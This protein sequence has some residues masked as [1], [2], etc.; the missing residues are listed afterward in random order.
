M[1]RDEP[2]TLQWKKKAA[3]GDQWQVQAPTPETYFDNYMRVMKDRIL[4]P[5]AAGG[6]NSFP[7][8]TIA[9][10][11]GS[12]L[13]KV[14]K[15]ELLYACVHN[16]PESYLFDF[17]EQQLAAAMEV[18]KENRP[19]RR[20]EIRQYL[21]EE[22]YNRWYDPKTGKELKWD[23]I[24]FCYEG[25]NIP[26]T[27]AEVDREERYGTGKCA[28]EKKRLYEY[29]DGEPLA[30]AY[31]V[32]CAPTRKDAKYDIF[33]QEKKRQEKRK[34]DIRTAEEKRKQDVKKAVLEQEQLRFERMLIKKKEQQ[35]RRDAKKTE[36]H[37]N[38]DAARWQAEFLKEESAE[39]KR[40]EYAK[41]RAQSQREAE[42]SFKKKVRALDDRYDELRDEV[43]GMYY[44]YR[45]RLEEK[46]EADE[47]ARHSQTNS[48]TKSQESSDSDVARVL[49]S[50]AI[51]QHFQRADSVDSEVVSGRDEHSE[52]ERSESGD[53]DVNFETSEARSECI[54]P[55]DSEGEQLEIPTLRRLIVLG[56]EHG[57]S[58][59]FQEMRQLRDERRRLVATRKAIKEHVAHARKKLRMPSAYRGRHADVL[60]Y[61]GD[62]STIK[63]MDLKQRERVAHHFQARIANEEHNFFIDSA[64]PDMDGWRAAQEAVPD[65]RSTDLAVYLQQCVDNGDFD[66]RFEWCKRMIPTSSAK[67]VH[68]VSRA[69]TSWDR[70]DEFWVE[71]KFQNHVSIFFFKFSIFLH[72]KCKNFV[73]GRGSFQGG[74]LAL[75]WRT[76][77]TFQA[78]LDHAGGAISSS[79]GD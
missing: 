12:M 38:W 75:R 56:V 54:Q 41:K 18:R 63:K 70:P 24:N 53:E 14:L 42:K 49:V 3:N 78:W 20:E 47:L 64:E 62:S 74:L 79:C 32:F 65:W 4:E 76:Y 25:A 9:A 26:I 30:M 39:K 55:E 48:P 68:R 19:H 45:K 67:V 33:T 21:Q 31:G 2:W 40:T 10:V 27:D 7:H 77:V 17:S 6:D 37:S 51:L 46:Y 73:L 22:R 28:I 71:E 58:A 1:H 29:R 44:A 13:D 50:G 5:S 66:P 72:S 8:L 61:A 57:Q 36:D 23:W 43:K 52:R 16:R 34:Q 35:R 59:L 69:G 15:H 11:W 60:Q